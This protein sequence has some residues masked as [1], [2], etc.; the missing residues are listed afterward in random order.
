MNIC[1]Y[2]Y[3]IFCSIA[4]SFTY[5]KV[6]LQLFTGSSHSLI[7]NNF[8]TS[9]NFLTSPCKFYF[10]NLSLYKNMQRCCSCTPGRETVGLGIINPACS[11]L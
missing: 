4:H 1:L 10:Q 5:A 6:L 8:L 11:L 3:F 9:A 2:L 7:L